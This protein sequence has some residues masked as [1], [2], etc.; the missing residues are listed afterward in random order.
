MWAHSASKKPGTLAKSLRA[1]QS[2]NGENLP[3]VFAGGKG[4]LLENFVSTINE[5]GLAEN[6]IMLG[7]VDDNQLSWLYRN[8]Y[9]FVYPSLFEGFGLPVLEAMSLGAAVIT[10]NTTSLPEVVGDAGLLVNP[11][12]AEEIMTAMQQ[13]QTDDA[14]QK[15]L[16]KMALAR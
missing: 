8:C 16:K 6:V 15:R 2:Q 3:L 7:Y 11:Y 10:S 9:A 5:L 1:A 14:P 4:W 12:Q 13:M